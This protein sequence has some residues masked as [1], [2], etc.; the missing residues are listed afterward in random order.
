VATDKDISG[1]P[2][3]TRQT[4]T[5][6][7]R[8][9]TA[10][11]AGAEASGAG[12]GGQLLW[13]GELDAE[14]R[15]LV[16]AGN[17][18]GAATMAATQDAVAQRQAVRDGIVDFLVTS[19]D[20]AL[21]ILKNQLRKRETVAVCIGLPIDV[22]AREMADRG[23]LPDVTR[24]AVISGGAHGRLPNLSSQN[25][26]LVIWRVSAAPARW[27]P[28]LDAIALDC[29][30]AS[31]RIAG[32]WLRSSGRYL[33]RAGLEAHMVWTTCEFGARYIDQVTRE[34]ERGEIR[35]AVGVEVHHGKGPPEVREIL[36]PG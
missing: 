26:A 3:F 16:V 21:R 4:Y 23:V 15:A 19:L 31:E 20:E 17:I 6:F 32:R 29:L 10:L 24:D 5:H 30:D 11:P 22:V 27:L 12:Q 36:P 8:L 2:E 13:A 35:A 9:M 1:A 14:G 25:E 33:G 34:V 18:A 28:K 7:A